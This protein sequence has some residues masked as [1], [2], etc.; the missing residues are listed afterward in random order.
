MSERKQEILEAAC[1]VI[2]RRGVR[3][4]RVEEI[5]READVSV[6]LI[7]YYFDGRANLL[8]R[9][10]EYVNDRAGLYTETRP[11]AGA[12]ARER[13]DDVLLREIQD[14]PAVIENVIVW[15][16]VT[17]SA[18]FEPNLRD[19]VCRSNE[20]WAASLAEL[21]RTGQQEGTVPGGIAADDAA[22]RLTA[23]VDGLS[24]RWLTGAMTAEVARDLLQQAIAR[25]LGVPA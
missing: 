2:G 15:S 7:Y 14:D 3:G 24:S 16:E 8:Q 13:I 25:E 21:I 1:R 17:A 12:S 20:R 22:V 9:V 18:L 23:L 6:A 5:A 4:L 11:A 19:A 10:L